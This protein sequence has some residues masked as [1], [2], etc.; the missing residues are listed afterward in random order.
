MNTLERTSHFAAGNNT[1]HLVSI[2]T[3]KMYQF[4]CFQ[5]LEEVWVANLLLKVHH[6]RFYLRFSLAAP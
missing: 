2:N 1:I 5:Q 3:K 4:T 6:A